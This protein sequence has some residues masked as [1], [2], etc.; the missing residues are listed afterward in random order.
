VKVAD[1]CGSPKGPWLL[2]ETLLRGESDLLGELF[3]HL[4]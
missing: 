3:S 2:D 1:Y 4:S